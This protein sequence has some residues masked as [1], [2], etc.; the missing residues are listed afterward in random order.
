MEEGTEYLGHFLLGKLDILNDDD[1]F[2]EIVTTGKYLVRLLEIS[3]YPRRQSINEIRSSEL[4][5]ELLCTNA[6]LNLLV[7]GYLYGIDSSS[8][9]SSSSDSSSS[10]LKTC[11]LS[12]SEDV[13]GYRAE[14]GVTSMQVEDCDLES[15]YTLPVSVLIIFISEYSESERDQESDRYLGLHN[16]CRIVYSLLLFD[17]D[18]AL[19]YVLLVNREYILLKLLRL[20]SHPSVAH[21]LKLIMSFENEK[22]CLTHGRNPG[23]ERKGRKTL[24]SVGFTRSIFGNFSF[25]LEGLLLGRQERPGGDGEIGTRDG[26]NQNWSLLAKSTSEMIIDILETGFRRKD[27]IEYFKFKIIEIE[28]TPLFQRERGS[29]E[30][31]EDSQLGFLESQKGILTED[32]IVKLME[33]LHTALDGLKDE[34]RAQ[35]VDLR[36]VANFSSLASSLIAVTNAIV[37]RGLSEKRRIN[38]RDDNKEGGAGLGRIGNWIG[39]GSSSR[40]IGVAT[41][42]NLIRGY[43]RDSERKVRLVL[44]NSG[45][46]NVIGGFAWDLVGELY[47]GGSK[48]SNKSPVISVLVEIFAYIEILL[49]ENDL[50]LLKRLLS[51]LTSESERNVPLIWDILDL[52]L[53]QSTCKRSGLE[54]LLSSLVESCF[55]FIRRKGRT[56]GFQSKDS[57]K[58]FAKGYFILEYLESSNFFVKAIIFARKEDWIDDRMLRR[59]NESSFLYHSGHGRSRSDNRSGCSS[60]G[61][62]S[63]GLLGM[64]GTHKAGD[65]GDFG[66]LGNCVANDVFKELR[67][68]RKDFSWV[69]D[70]FSRHGF[71]QE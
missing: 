29:L 39:V 9:D 19:N 53:F 62:F 15:V 45:F 33:A 63:V 64:L 35:S 8:S 58:K 40:L 34:I 50:G 43:K 60:S 69:S 30:W 56:P 25:V 32:I 3:L 49:L 44:I 26:D 68:L 47:G 54:E 28:K 71:G 6:L 16:F 11:H 51:K 37:R 5:T 2:K 67:S 10:C 17:L 23:D 65:T 70:M 61:N 18:W 55:D 7:N 36:R 14:R 12:D 13:N 4:A 24:R 66:I 22:S 41:P 31:L 46:A 20:V 1:S 57:L 38:N 48:L 42:L 52:V 21:L 59:R 27:V